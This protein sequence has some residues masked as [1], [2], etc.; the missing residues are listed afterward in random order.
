MYLYIPRATGMHTYVLAYDRFF[1]VKGLSTYKHLIEIKFVVVC[2]VNFI[3]TMNVELAIQNDIIYYVSMYLH[4]YK[5]SYILG[6]QQIFNSFGYSSEF[7]YSNSKSIFGI[8]LFI[9][10]EMYSWK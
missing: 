1:K 9:C 2:K 10:Y 4:M 8:R 6:L 5:Y 7:W 3:I